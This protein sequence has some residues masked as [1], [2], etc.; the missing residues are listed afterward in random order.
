MNITDYLKDISYY[1]LLSK[2]EEYELSVKASSGDN[3]ARERLIISNLR[4][5]VS[6]AKKYI[7]IGMPIQDLIQEGNIG[8]IKAVE[9]FNPE[10]DIR[11]STYA[12]WWIK[13]SILRSLNMTKGLMRYPSY[14]HDNLSK[15]N[16]FIKQYKEDFSTFPD[17]SVISRELNIKESE[18]EKCLNL[19]NV[20][21]ISLEEPVQENV[22]LHNIVPDTNLIEDI[23]FETF[24]NDEISFLL[25][26]LSDKEKKVIIYRFGLF[27]SEPLTLEDIG[28]KMSLTRERIRQI[29]VTALE[30][31]KISAKEIMA[32]YS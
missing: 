25:D 11:F 31:L 16:K 9:K 20:S 24:E 2:D 13:Q 29:Q 18:V 8:L 17:K 1:P 15:I 14:V 30:K 19:I 28:E 6:V 32:S 27:D 5:V 26:K 21:F 4:L 22:T 12:T 7:N 3:Y 23:I 10:L